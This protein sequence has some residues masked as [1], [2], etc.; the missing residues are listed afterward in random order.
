MKRLLRVPLQTLRP[1]APVILYVLPCP[2]V[3]S[4]VPF[5][6]TVSAMLLWMLTGRVCLG[7][8]TVSVGT[9]EAEKRECGV[10]LTSSRMQYA[11]KLDG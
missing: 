1:A 2:D 11:G 7:P 4:T 8:Q 9:Q 10:L 3:S 6:A 5:S